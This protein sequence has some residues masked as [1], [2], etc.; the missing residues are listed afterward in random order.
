MKFMPIMY[1][2][3]IYR[4]AHTHYAFQ[5]VFTTTNE[6]F[7]NVTELKKKTHINTH[8]A[9]VST[10]KTSHVNHLE[11]FTAGAA[12]IVESGRMTRVALTGRDI[13]ATGR[14]T[15]QLFV[16]RQVVTAFK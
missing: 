5:S 4:H 2:C 16:P 10:E 1:K 8:N 12:G 13:V 9:A 14:R 7:V 6:N 3:T 11:D 15:V